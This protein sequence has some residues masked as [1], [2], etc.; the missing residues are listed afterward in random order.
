VQWV[1]RNHKGLRGSSIIGSYVFKI[2]YELAPI[3]NAVNVEYFKQI[4]YGKAKDYIAL[5]MGNTEPASEAFTLP[6][7]NAIFDPYVFKAEKQLYLS[8]TSLPQDVKTLVTLVCERD[9]HA[10]QDPLILVVKH[11][12]DGPEVIIKELTSPQV[13]VAALENMP[14]VKAMYAGELVKGKFIVGDGSLGKLQIR[15]EAKNQDHFAKYIDNFVSTIVPN[16]LMIYASLVEPERQIALE[17]V[18]TIE[19]YPDIVEKRIIEL[20]GTSITRYRAN[21]ARE[22]NE[23]CVSVMNSVSTVV[24][25]IGH[26]VEFYLPLTQWLT[27]HRLLRSRKRGDQLIDIYGN[28]KEIAVDATMPAFAAVRKSSEKYVAKLYSSGDTEVLSM[29][30]EYLSQ[31]E[32]AKILIKNDPLLAAIILRAIG[33]QDVQAQIAPDLLA[34]LPQI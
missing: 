14:I 8:C 15:P 17:H 20:F 21:A 33:P 19:I 12:T 23:I 7:I 31:P 3:A 6:R 9:D 1:F 10:N 5:L 11:L 16:G 22:Q 29:S 30:M 32:T 27:I 2:G 28:G 25:E 4:A 26:Q 34:L 13:L 24:H 18:A